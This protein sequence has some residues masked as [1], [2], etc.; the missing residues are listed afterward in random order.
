MRVIYRVTLAGLDVRLV[1]SFALCLWASLTATG[2]SMAHYGQ[3][4]GSLWGLGE[5]LPQLG[6]GTRLPSVVGRMQGVVSSTWP[7]LVT[8]HACTVLP[9]TPHTTHSRSG[10][11]TAC[12]THCLRCAWLSV[13]LHSMCRAVKAGAWHLPGSHPLRP[14]VHLRASHGSCTHC[15][16]QLHTVR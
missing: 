13:C 1:C 4:R 7:C 15:T 9:C 11:L 6:T 12:I 2:I 14:S 5:G 8:V 10:G 16:R 3:G